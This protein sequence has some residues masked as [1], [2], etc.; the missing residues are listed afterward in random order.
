MLRSIAQQ[1]ALDSEFAATGN[2][3]QAVFGV[4]RGPRARYLATGASKAGPPFQMSS[5]V[6]S[7]ALTQERY[8]R[9]EEIGVGASAVVYRGYDPVL[10]RSVA[11]K[12]LHPHLAHHQKA[13]A[14]LAREAHAV[15]RLRHPNIV[16][17]YDYSV[18]QEK[19]PCLVTELIEGGSLREALDKEAI[20]HPA[21]AAVAGLEIARALSCAHQASIVHRDIKPENIM[22]GP[23][24]H[25]KLADF[26]IAHCLDEQSL[27][28]T[29]Q[30]IGSPAY[31]APEIIT[32][33]P[34]DARSDLFSLGVLLYLLAT[35]TLPF[36]AQHP[37][38]LLSQIVDGEYKRPSQRNPRIDAQLEAIIQKCLHRDPDLRYPSACA[39][40][41]DLE[42]YLQWLGLG[43]DS[44]CLQVY[45][46]QGPACLAALDQRIN[47]TL[48]KEAKSANASGQRAQALG[49][50][51]V[52]LESAPQ[53]PQAKQLFRSIHRANS[54]RRRLGY[55][56]CTGLG[57]AAATGLA[58]AF[59]H[60]SPTPPLHSLPQAPTRSETTWPTLTQIPD[61]PKLAATTLALAPPRQAPSDGLK[62][63]CQVRIQGLPV[64]MRAH[65]ELSSASGQ[66]PLP[67]DAQQPLAL[68]MGAS[69]QSWV[70]K[71]KGNTQQT[72]DAKVIV[73]ALR[74]Q[75]T[76]TIQ[77]H[78]RPSSFE[79]TGLNFDVAKLVVQCVHPCKGPDARKQI[80]RE[81]KKIQL[82]PDRLEQAVTLRFWAPGYHKK[83]TQYRIRPGVNRINL[84]LRPLAR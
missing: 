65:Y 23:G 60:A 72:F 57:L 49:M 12:V 52:V 3:A 7:E 18:G 26:G 47:Q 13:Q 77:A 6:Q 61:Q 29:G 84:R 35:G 74:C 31:M 30:L 42:G 37:H 79:F 4:V 50:L 81:F 22:I 82:A 40:G 48:I 20:A 76:R 39:L 63:L 41:Q 55:A 19:A 1:R 2:F 43:A 28:V 56:L 73:D 70:L 62:P 58:L 25:L 59:T 69:A 27:T 11:L 44:D 54:L 15:A 38:A 80:A 78:P 68:P 67:R 9:G 8:E 66:L 14:R 5:A 71:A 16:E 36:D 64:T 53:D 51:S 32:G 83:E 33:E 34:M 17:V 46:Q 21:L 75:T 24:Q 10:R 45:L